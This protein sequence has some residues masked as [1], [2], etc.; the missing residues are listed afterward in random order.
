MT[1]IRHRSRMVQ[2]SV[3]QD[4]SDTLIATRW[5]VG[6]TS[7]PVTDP[8]DRTAPPAV[9]TT[10]TAD[11]F[12]LADTPVT[13]LDYF[14]EAQGESGPQTAPN[15][16]GLDEGTPGEATLLGLG[17]RDYE[18]PYRFNIAFLAASD[19]V[20]LA[21][22]ADLKDRYEGRTIGGDIIPLYDFNTDPT[23]PVGYLEI[24]MFRYVRNTEIVTADTVHLFFAELH[25]V[26]VV[27]S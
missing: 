25:L 18:Q 24:D 19:A 16:M 12:A 7:R 15:T 14:P 3:F 23:T 9:I 20:A 4:L 10:G 1:F 11:V 21:V 13:L 6:T 2:A 8:A 5:M 27:D 26:D 22:M 17:T